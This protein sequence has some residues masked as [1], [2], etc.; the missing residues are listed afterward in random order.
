MFT[1]N[2]VTETLDLSSREA[3]LSRHISLL[4]V[5]HRV[6]PGIEIT[7]TQFREPR[8]EERELNRNEF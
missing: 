3:L 7:P 6:E 8:K 1:G 2:D 5:N 4:P